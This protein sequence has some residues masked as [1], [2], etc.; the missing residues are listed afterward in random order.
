MKAF[1]FPGQGSQFPGMGFNLYQ[2]SAQAKSLFQISNKILNFDIAKIMF[3]GSSE[4]LKQTNVTQPA[5][6]IHST[7]LAKCINHFTPNMLAGHSL[8]EFS[9]LVAAKTLSFNDGLKLV[10]K[11]AELMHIACQEN[12]ST[13][14]AILGLESN[15][16]EGVYTASAYIFFARRSGLLL[17]C[18]V[19]YFW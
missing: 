10:M 4:D 11:R 6:F 8:G 2:K 13:M 15:I 7:I 14:A 1:I 19:A 18:S 9:A 17:F 16:I 3:D 5:I 12:D